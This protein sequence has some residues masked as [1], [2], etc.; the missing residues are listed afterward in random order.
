MVQYLSISI[1]NIHLIF[2]LYIDLLKMSKFFGVAF[3]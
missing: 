2:L 3:P 1:V